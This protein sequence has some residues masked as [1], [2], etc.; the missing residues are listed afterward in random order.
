MGFRRTIALDD[1]QGR[2]SVAKDRTDESDRGYPYVE[3]GEVS[4]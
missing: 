4:A 3:R 2:A 1:V